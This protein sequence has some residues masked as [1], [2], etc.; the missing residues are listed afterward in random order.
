MREGNI[1]KIMFLTALITSVSVFIINSCG[2]LDLYYGLWGNSP[3]KTGQVKVYSFTNGEKGKILDTTTLDENRFKSVLLDTT[4][5][6]LLELES[7]SVYDQ[8]NNEVL[9]S[10]PDIKWQ[11]LVTKPDFYAEYNINPITTIAAAL[12]MHKIR[13]RKLKKLEE[14]KEA[15]E[16]SNSIVGTHFGGIDILNTIPSNLDITSKVLS[17][18]IIYGLSIMPFME[19]SHFYVTDTISKKWDILSMNPL[20]IINMT[21]SIRSDILHDG[22]IDGVASQGTTDLQNEA[23]SDKLL[24][25][26]FARSIYRLIQNTSFNRT[27]LNTGDSL[28][29]LNSLT[30]SASPLFRPGSP[31]YPFDVDPPIINCSSPQQAETYSFNLQI[32]CSFHDEIPGIKDTQV[33]FNGQSVENF[34]DSNKD[35]YSIIDLPPGQTT[36]TISVVSIDSLGNKSSLLRDIFIN[37]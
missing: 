25:F 15:I 20:N 19:L 18:P 10:D 31:R 9:S 28:T 24:K 26:D 2:F 11:S 27:G 6:I 7:F 3:A 23:E 35:F 29:L 32:S 34:V 12:A 13:D 8:V 16:E 21:E 30:L 36:A 5:T 1:I 37:N 22:Y 14:I 33:F 17:K 4:G